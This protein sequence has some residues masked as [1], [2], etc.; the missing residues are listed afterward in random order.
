MAAAKQ[1]FVGDTPVD[2]FPSEATQKIPD[3]EL[4][5]KEAERLTKCEQKE[6]GAGKRAGAASRNPDDYDTRGRGG[7]GNTQPTADPVI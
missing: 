1:H 4:T 7:Q 2:S 6:P 5:K 3:D